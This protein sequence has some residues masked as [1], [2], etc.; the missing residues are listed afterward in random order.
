MTAVCEENT[1]GVWVSA[2]DTGT[3]FFWQLVRHLHG[4]LAHQHK[5]CLFVLR[6]VWLTSGV[7]PE[8]FLF[9]FLICIWKRF[10]YEKRHLDLKKKK[11][12]RFASVF[13][14]SL[15]FEVFWLDSI[16]SWCASRLME[17]GLW[18]KCWRTCQFVTNV[19]Y[20]L[21]YLDF[22][23]NSNGQVYKKKRQ[24]NVYF[25]PVKDRKK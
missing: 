1:V 23:I 2:G 8:M 10:V 6:A 19:S 18:N 13:V 9:F 14:R 4:W 25:I 3:H 11:F 16:N 15:C 20:V 12:L 24:K 21:L 22:N 5:E 7:C 17:T